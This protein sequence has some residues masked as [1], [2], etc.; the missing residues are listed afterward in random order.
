MNIYGTKQTLERYKLDTTEPA[1]IASDEERLFAYGIKVFYS[2]RKKCLQVVN[3][4]SKLTLII[5]D[6][7]NSDIKNLDTIIEDQIK[8]LFKNDSEMNEL[9]AKYYAD[10]SDLTINKLTD[11]SII[12]T[13]NRNQMI[14]VDSI[15]IANEIDDDGTCRGLNK[16][17]NFDYLQTITLNKKPRYF[18]P[19]EEFK[20]LLSKMYS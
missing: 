3:F 19:A 6:V 11:R 20:N 16:F 15:N 2:N 8:Q 14:L 10:N 9:L 12:S 1:I 4:A 5:Y 7:K 13:L 18:Y 17:V